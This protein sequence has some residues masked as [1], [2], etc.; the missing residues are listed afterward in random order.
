MKTLSIILA[1]SIGGCSTPIIPPAP[2]TAA[3]TVFELKASEGAALAVA[4]QY[5]A[6]PTC[7]TA[8]PICKTANVVTSLQATDNVA[9]AAIDN[10]ERLVRDP[11]F[12]GSGTALKALDAASA[13]VSALA[14]I[15][16]TLKVR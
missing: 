15:A 6:L 4:V 2:K 9:A 7:P 5:K 1:L 8:S 16:S 14:S 11:A 3:Q 12:A 13:A 10:A